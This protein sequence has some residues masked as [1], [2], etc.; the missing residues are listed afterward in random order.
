M[1]ISGRRLPDPNRNKNKET[2]V[3]LTKLMV[4]NDLTKHLSI[5]SSIYIY[6]HIPNTPCMVHL[7]TFGYFLW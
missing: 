6:I 2:A 1:D 3:K 4:D 7:P 5:L